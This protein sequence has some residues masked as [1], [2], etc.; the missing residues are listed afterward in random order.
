MSEL[1]VDQ[2][3]DVL[4]APPG[5][6][7]GVTS[8]RGLPVIDT[9][10]QATRPK[11]AALKILFANKFFYLKGG[12]EAVMFDEIDLMKQQQVEVVEF[13]IELRLVFRL[14]EGLPVNFAG[15][16]TQIGTFVHSFAGGGR[17]DFQPDPQ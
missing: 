6:R 5:R 10:R 2:G 7:S 9:A 16:E 14:V 12:A 11:R 15:Q 13:S 17:Q 4:T 1:S 3:G 8:K